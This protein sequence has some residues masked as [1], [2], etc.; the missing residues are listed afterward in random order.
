M[1]KRFPGGVQTCPL[2]GSTQVYRLGTGRYRCAR[3]KYT[4]NFMTGTWLGRIKISASKWLALVRAYDD[5]EKT[6]MAAKSA[7]TGSATARRAFDLINEAIYLKQC[8]ENQDARQR[9]RDDK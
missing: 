5:M 3:N 7:G 9:I 2:C 8:Q 1:Q 6:C 4:F